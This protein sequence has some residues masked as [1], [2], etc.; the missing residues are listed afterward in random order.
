MLILGTLI[1]ILFIW[2]SRWAMWLRMTIILVLSILVKIR[3]YYS[4]QRLDSQSRTLTRLKDLCL[5]FRLTLAF[6]SSNGKSTAL[7]IWFQMLEV[8]RVE[9]SLFLRSLSSS[10]L[11]KTY[12]FTWSRSFTAKNSSQTLVKITKTTYSITMLWALQDSIYSSTCHNVLSV[13]RGAAHR[14]KNDFSS[15]ASCSIKKRSTSSSS[16]MPC[17]RLRLPWRLFFPNHNLT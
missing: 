5:Q 15:M 14:K 12:T 9:S 8:W 13:A 11:S 17:W 6:V 1:K 3:N 10:S 4:C 2:T 7:P 16:S